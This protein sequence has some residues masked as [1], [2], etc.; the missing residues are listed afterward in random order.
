VITT[1]MIVTTTIIIMVV[2]VIENLM[3]HCFGSFIN[4]IDSLFGLFTN[5]SDL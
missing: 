1:T 3:H 4:E 2:I 5:P